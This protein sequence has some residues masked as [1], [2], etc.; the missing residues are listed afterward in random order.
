MHWHKHQ[1]NFGVIGE[2][3]SFG[4]CTTK[5]TVMLFTYRTPPEAYSSGKAEWT[6]KV[7]RRYPI[8]PRE[9]E[10]ESE[11]KLVMLRRYDTIYSENC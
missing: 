6:S 1:H 11:L 8:G 4:G 3:Q 9:R 5:S 10:R 2:M 7:H